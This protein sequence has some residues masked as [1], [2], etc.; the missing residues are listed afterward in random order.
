MELKGTITIFPELKEG[1]NEKGETESFI[2]CRGTIS[3]KNKEG[4][5]V[6]K[7]VNVNFAGSNFPKEKIDKLDPSKCY[8]LDIEKGFLAVREFQNSVG[9]KRELEIVVLE[10]K[11]TKSK[12]VNRVEKAPSDLP[13]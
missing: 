6:N 9:F 11:L 10:G 1:K 7:S 8:S 2:A 5:Y 12:E 4:V 13:F 3:S